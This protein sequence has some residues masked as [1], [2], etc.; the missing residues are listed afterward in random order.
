ME[1]SLSWEV[2][3]PTAGEEIL[4]ILRNLKLK[5]RVHNSLAES[6]LSYPIYTTFLYNSF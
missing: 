5:Y 4:R 2:K 3:G 6:D 1:K